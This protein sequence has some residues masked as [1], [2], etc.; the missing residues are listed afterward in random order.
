MVVPAAV[1]FFAF[2]TFA[3]LQGAFY[4]FTNWKGYGDFLIVGIKNYVNVFRDPLM[5]MTYGF[6]FKFAIVTSIIVNLL[7][8]CLAMGLNSNIFG[9]TALRAIYFLPNVLGTLVISYIFRYIF[10]HL[11]PEI[12]RHYDILW[13]SRNILGSQGLAWIGVVIVTTWQSTAFNSILYISGLQTID[14]QL[15][16]AAIMDGAGALRRFLAVTVPMLVPFFTINMVLTMRNYLTVFDTVVALTGGGP[17]KVTTSVSLNIYRS[18]FSAQQFGYQS[19]NAVVFFLI[20]LAVALFQVKIMQRRE[21]AIR[22]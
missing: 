12:G 5:G 13:L 15:Y 3:A 16:E 22:G 18:G 21:L 1:L 20:L 9:K 6:T 17:G 4:S 19:A 7:S 2:H 14:R 10:S 11:L 8:L